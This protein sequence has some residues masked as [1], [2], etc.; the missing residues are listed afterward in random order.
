MID[1]TLL[2]ILKYKSEYRKIIGRVPM[3]SMDKT[4]VALLQDFGKYFEKFPEHT[5]ID[6]QTFAPLFG[7][8]H[9]KLT[10]EQKHGYATILKKVHQD[11]PEGERDQIIQ[12]MLELRLSTDLANLLMKF[13]D[14]ELPNIHNATEQVIQ[15]FR[16]DARIKGLDYIRP[17][18]DALLNREINE[19]GLRWRL[20]CLNRCMRGLR[21]GD[22]GILAARPDKGKTTALV[23]EITFMAAQTD[24]CVV[25]LNNEGPGDRIY[26]R[27]WQAALGEQMSGLIELHQRGRLMTE[28]EA[29]IKGAHDKIRVVDIHGQDNH[30][31][32]R[33]I[34]ENK[35]GLVVFDM[36]DNIRGFGNAARTDLALEHMYQWA[37]EVAVKY[38]FAGIAAS[39]ISVD[40]DNKQF[41]ADHMLKDS[42][43][44][45]PGTPVRMF[46]GSTRAVETIKEGELVM[47]PDST[48]RVVSG[49]VTGKQGMYRVTHGDK[50]FV[51][52]EGHILTCIKST[53]KPMN[54]HQKGDI[55]DLPLVYFLKNPS[56]LAHY[57]AVNARVEYAEADLSIDPYLFGLW[58]GDGAKREMRITSGDPEIQEYLRGLPQYKSEYKQA[59]N[60]I[61]FYLGSRKQLDDVGVR[62]NKHIPSVYKKSSVDQRKALLAGIMDSD[63]YVDHGTSVVSMSVKRKRLMRDIREVAR[64]LGYNTFT[65]S[66]P[67]TK[68]VSVGF[69]CTDELPCLL[70]RKV[71]KAQQQYRKMEIEY[72][73]EGDF[74]GF[75]VSGDGRYVHGDYTVLHNTGKQGACD[76]IIMVGAVDDPGYA[77]ARFIGTPKNKLRREGAEGNPKEMVAFKPQVARLED[78]METEY[79]GEEETQSVD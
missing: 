71:Y 33:I 78:A 11:V 1:L 29:A 18:V 16:L 40:G 60:C 72:V 7:A 76:F 36:I 67:S 49:P 39:Q 70:K 77:N 19:D 32:E 45:A 58:L 63:G 10:A 38:E 20:N 65:R 47:G 43:C 53:V 56:R 22:F 27:L 34:E 69:S 26:P 50:S 46:D 21:P 12:S 14:G 5:R 74:A 75:T 57:K 42:K 28:Y 23:S 48:P 9:P 30:A 55:V 17:D 35:P 15:Q 62:N 8:W 52:N 37:R 68:S 25:W 64:S 2:R 24:Q 6:L 59:S 41:P 79:D 44:L 61:D 51:C 13:E 54:G 31:V 66:K 4:T 73:G 3:E